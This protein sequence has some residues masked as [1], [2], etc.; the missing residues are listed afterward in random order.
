MGGGPLP[1]KKLR[2]PRLPPA[3]A[4]HIVVTNDADCP[5]IVPSRRPGLPFSG[6]AHRRAG[7]RVH[8]RADINRPVVPQ[9]AT[10]PVGAAG[11]LNFLRRPTLDPFE[12]YVLGPRPPVPFRVGRRRRVEGSF[13][14]I[15]G[16]PRRQ[17]MG[18]FRPRSR[19]GRITLALPALIGHA[20]QVLPFL[21]PPLP[22]LFG[23]LKKWW[24]WT[25][26]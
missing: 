5:G 3:D 16:I 26:R 25:G 6:V 2:R 19:P 1:A 24:L 20:P 4:I 14:R 15:P 8:V 21:A 7:S 12:E 10:I 11:V 17:G 9:M 23:K 18:S 13:G 22:F